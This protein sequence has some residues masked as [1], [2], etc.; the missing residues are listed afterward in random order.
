MREPG[1]CSMA[2]NSLTTAPSLSSA[3]KLKVGVESE[4]MSIRQKRDWLHVG[5]TLR[6]LSFCL[7]SLPQGR[8]GS[9]PYNYTILPGNE[10][11]LLFE[12]MERRPWWRETPEKVL[13]LT[14]LTEL[15]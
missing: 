12:C 5:C 4:L 1:E 10:P 15:R 7:H 11:Q 14:R 8:L 3:T 6:P 9:P 2:K 13:S